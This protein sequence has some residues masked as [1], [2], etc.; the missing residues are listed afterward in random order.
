[1][2]D[3]YK[4][5]TNIITSIK[6][7]AFFYLGSGAALPWPIIVNTADKLSGSLELTV[8]KATDPTITETSHSK[9][10]IA[11]RDT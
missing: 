2:S 1:M 9:L 6:I 11:G 8:G 7:L 3:N 5:L 4:E 10:G